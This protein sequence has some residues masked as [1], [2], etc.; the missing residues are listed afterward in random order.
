MFFQCGAGGRG[1]VAALEGVVVW[2]WDWDW[3]CEWRWVW[4]ENMIV[5]VYSGV[6]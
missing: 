1:A 3:D 4:C 5:K 2:C 6:I